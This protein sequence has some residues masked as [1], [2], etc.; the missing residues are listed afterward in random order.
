MQNIAVRGHEES[1]KDIWEVSDINRGNF[2]ELLHLRYK[3]LPWLQSNLQ[4]Q[5]QLHAQWTSP[6]IQNELLAIVSDLVLERITTEVRK[7]GYFGIIMDG[8]SDI[9]RTEE[10]SLCLRYVING[11]TKETFVGFFATASTE[12]EVLYELA[13]TAINK[14]DLRLENI[15]ECFGIR[16]GLA[17]RMKECSPLG[18]YVH[19]YDH[20]LN[21]ALQDTMTENETLRNTLGTIQS[22]YNFLHGSTKRHALFKD[23]EIHE[24][25]IALTLK[26]LSTTRWS[27]RWAAVRAVLEQV[28]RIMEAL[29]TLSK[30]RDPKTYSESNSLLH[31]I[32]DFEFVYGLMVL[33]LIL[34]NTD[35]LSRYLQGQ[36]MDVITAKKTADAVVKTLS[37]C[38]NE[39]SFTLMW[40]HADIIAQ[41]N[42]NRNRGYAIYLQRCQ[43]YYTSIDKVVSELQ[44]RFEGNDQE[45]LCALGEI[46]ISRSPSINN[47][48]TVSNFYGVDSEMLSSEKSSFENY[49]C[50]D[51][52]QR[53]NAAMMVK[54]MH[55]NGLHDILPVL[56]K[57]ASI[58]ATIPATSCSAERSFSAHRRIKTFLRSTMGQ[59]RL[60]SIAVIN[61]EREYAN[62]T[63]QNDMHRII[64]IFGRRSNRSSYF[65]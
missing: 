40:S 27:C 32:C 41:K 35:N 25:D 50:G 53:K 33:K 56:Y 19:C 43:V 62:K 7:S 47:I 55:Q 5:L 44:S 49:D 12:G 1:R 30:D 10:V 37:N 59:D 4:A 48:Q 39:E 23:I 26:S 6:S 8:T 63:M 42:Q 2:L 57:V 18:I 22:L 52:F 36:Q 54:T 64:D 45:V 31:S 46:V 28:P 13:K 60:S 34:S 51:P 21:L 11:E 38:R 24:E 15:A 29:V 65:F 9:S 61:I 17:K 14:L 58:L 3:D 16:K 20:L